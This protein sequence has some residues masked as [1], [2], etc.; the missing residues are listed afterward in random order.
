MDKLIRGAANFNS[1]ADPRLKSEFARLASEGQ[2]PS[3]LFI[4]CVDSRVLPSII[5]NAPPGKML[6]LRNVGNFVPSPE[7]SW[8]GGGTSVSATLAFA[9]EVL[10][11][12]HI[13]VMGHSECG[14]MSELYARRNDFRT[15]ALGTWLRNGRRSLQRFMSSELSGEGLSDVNRLSQ[16]NVLSSL[17]SLSIYAEVRSRLDRMQL[18]LHGWWFDIGNAQVLALEP[19]AGRFVPVEQAYPSAV[20]GAHNPKAWR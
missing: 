6:T 7:D 16:L 1:N 11:V 15:D 10:N 4:T 8:V 19:R 5:T 18:T 14:G 12:R 20:A 2:T 17:E 9:L 13:V 3:T